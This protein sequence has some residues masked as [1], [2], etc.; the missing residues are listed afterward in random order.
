VPRLRELCGDGVETEALSGALRELTPKD[1]WV[2]MMAEQWQQRGANDTTDSEPAK[3]A[4]VD[5]FWSFDF[6]K[7][8]TPPP[9]LCERLGF[10]A[11][12]GRVNAFVG[13][14]GG[15]K[16]WS[17][18]AAGLA[19]ATGTKVFGAFEC[20]PGV[21]RHIDS[22]MSAR[23]TMRRYVKLARG[24]GLL[25]EMRSAVVERRMGVMG[26]M[27][28][29]AGGKPDP[30]AYA[31]LR[32][33]LEGVDLLIVDSLR[34]IAPGIDENSA[35]FSEVLAQLRHVSA[36]TNTAVLML[37]H[38]GKSLTSK[39]GSGTDAVRGE[40]AAHWVLEDG[41]WTMHKKHGD[42]DD[43]CEPFSTT[44]EQTGTFAEQASPDGGGIRIRVVGVEEAEA[45]EAD[46]V[47]SF[48]ARYGFEG[49]S[50]RDVEKAAPG[51]KMS[52]RAAV[53]AVATLLKEERAYRSQ[54]VNGA[55]SAVV[56]AVQKDGISHAA[57]LK[58]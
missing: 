23:T 16:T 1:Q 39:N 48:L 22:D 19:V 20:R 38:T 25:D 34:R 56:I 14:P 52:A 2:E 54:G 27:I 51:L 41:E 24:A 29:T 45:S 42:V 47:W 13:A 30:K 18:V 53:R 50:Q 31:L 7:E 33:H 26:P 32:T 10:V 58:K 43:L 15:G 4:A 9:M 36:A 37:H 17:A 3:A 49:C 21:V 6:F 35:A 46:R 28:L 5:G 12:G 57:P 8:T 44:F 55:S 40:W 11:E